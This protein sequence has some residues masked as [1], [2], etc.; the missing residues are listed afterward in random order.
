VELNS[1]HAA[2]A[3]AHAVL[4]QAEKHS[5]RIEKLAEGRVASQAQHD[6]GLAALR[7]AQA[8]VS[9]RQA[10]LVGQGEATH[11]T[12]VQQLDSIYADFTQSVSEL[13]Q[14]R[15]DLESGALKRISPDTAK[16]RLV[17]DDGAVYPY[18]G[19]LLF[20]DASVDRSTSQLT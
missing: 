6:L 11:L 10:D 9:A 17:L 12:T 15:R 3:K 1:A 19:R 18:V 8:D 13:R 16:V 20:S 14:L 2:L 4:E 7:Q 5:K